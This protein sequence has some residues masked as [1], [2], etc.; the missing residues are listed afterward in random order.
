ME[1][2]YL[3]II[4]YY[5]KSLCAKALNMEHVMTKVIQVVNFIRS[6]GL[7]HHQFNSFLEEFGSEHSGVPYHTE[8]RWLS[9]G[10]VLIFFRAA[11][12]SVQQG[13]GHREL[14]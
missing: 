11:C 1:V 7:N 3:F 10:K 4:A 6:K 5:I 9:R 8:V 12:H 14:R 2:S 13:E